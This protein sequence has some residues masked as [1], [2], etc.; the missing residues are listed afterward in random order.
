MSVATEPGPG[1]WLAGCA[2]GR[3]PERNH[4]PQCAP[5]ASGA[6]PLPALERHRRCRLSEAAPG[7]ALRPGLLVSVREGQAGPALGC[8][9]DEVLGRNFQWGSPGKTDG[10]S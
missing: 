7:L 10:V 8:Y 6:A 3:G 9:G 1:A 4:P 2:G 5:Q